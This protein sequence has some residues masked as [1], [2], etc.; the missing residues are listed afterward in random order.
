MQRSGC[1]LRNTQDSPVDLNEHLIIIFYNLLS[2][3]DTV[4]VRET[5]GKCRQRPYAVVYRIT[6]Q[7]GVTSSKI[8]DFSSHHALELLSEVF[9]QAIV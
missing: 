3:G 6:R 9:A 5:Y 2:L 8:V 7:V 1:F 4:C